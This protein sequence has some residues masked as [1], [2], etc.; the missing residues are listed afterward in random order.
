MA[1]RKYEITDAFRYEAYTPEGPVS[2]EFSPGVTGD[3]LTDE[4]ALYLEQH[5]VPF[6]LAVVVDDT[7]PPAPPADSKPAPAPTDKQEKA[8]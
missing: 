3:D 8:K 6:G 4:Q 1:A 5:A 2:G 7:A